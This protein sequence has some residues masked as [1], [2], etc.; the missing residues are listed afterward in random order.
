METL[1]GR[2]VKMTKLSG[3]RWRLELGAH[4]I[5]IEKTGPS[6]AR[7]EHQNGDLIGNYP[8]WDRAMADAF[9]LFDEWDGA[10]KPPTEPVGEDTK[11]VKYNVVW[12]GRTARECS[13]TVME[14]VDKEHWDNFSF[15]TLH[16]VDWSLRRI[17]HKIDVPIDEK[18][19]WH[20][21]EAFGKIGRMI[22]DLERIL[23]IYADKLEQGTMLWTDI[24]I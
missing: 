2:K 3:F 4:E 17:V 12:S 14:Y 7:L 15:V 5:F 11:E 23:R 9:R 6:C 13:T 24:Q 1:Q 19:G 10:P 21:N 20:P 22:E 16:I 18:R 8:V